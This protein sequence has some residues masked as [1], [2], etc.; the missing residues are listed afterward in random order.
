[1]SRGVHPITL[2]IAS[3]DQSLLE[4]KGFSFPP[5]VISRLHRALSSEP[6]GAGLAKAGQPLSEHIFVP[7]V[8]C[9][10]GCGPVVERSKVLFSLHSTNAEGKVCLCECDAVVITTST[11][12]VCQCVVVCLGAV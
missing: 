11:F 12:C 1:M 3:F 2:S 9:L 5:G 4:G 8:G 7:R 10:V 6:S